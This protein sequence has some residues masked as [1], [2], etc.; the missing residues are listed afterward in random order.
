M[1]RD[2]PLQCTPLQESCS[3][4]TVVLDPHRMTE[5]VA[6]IPRKTPPGTGNSQQQPYKHQNECVKR[7]YS[8][9][10]AE[11]E[12]SCQMHPPN[13]SRKQQQRKKQHSVRRLF[14]EAAASEGRKIKDLHNSCISHCKMATSRLCKEKYRKYSCKSSGQEH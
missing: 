10:A 9:E 12:N 3:K 2:I 13:E 1:T 5:G 14:C 8:I 11:A 6:V 4:T 7:Q